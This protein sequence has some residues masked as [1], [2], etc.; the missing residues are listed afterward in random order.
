MSDFQS[1]LPLALA[2]L[3]AVGSTVYF[4]SSKVKKPVLD[5]LK[6]QKFPLVEKK[7]IS[8]NT[9][10][11]RFGLPKEDD[12]LGLPIGQHISV[13]AS[14]DG[15]E[16][17]RSYTPTS[18]DDDRGHFDLLIKTYPNGNLSRVFSDLKLGDTLNVRGPKGNFTYTPG[19]VKSFGM[20]AGG[21][22]ITPMY[23]II[24]AILK[25]P[26]DKTQINL[27]FANV[28]QEDIL[29][30]DELD[31]LS[32]KHDNFNLHY[33]L[34]T[35]PEGWTGGV[36]FVTQEMIKEWC[37]APSSDTKVLLCGPPPMV[38]AMS[39]YCVD[40]GFEKPRAISK[41]EDQI[42]KF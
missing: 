23:Q 38:K 7:I 30:K 36:G 26:K 27:I 3:V 13:M 2:I 25:N 6:F 42:F 37:P 34:N 33:V 10:I 4:V 5:K 20:I 8:H 9:A 1:Y 40:L 35:P 22:G 15:K 12:V 17:M 24:K 39:G 19:L 31:A 41:L 32:K 28:N 14:V 16:V 18:S 29:L 21:T 11:Y